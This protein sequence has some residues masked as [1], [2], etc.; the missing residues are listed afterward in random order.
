VV[1]REDQ[2]EASVAVRMAGVIEHRNSHDLGCRGRAIGR[3][4]HAYH[5]Y[6]E[7]ASGPTVSKTSWTYVRTL[8]GPGRPLCRPAQ[9]RTGKAED[10]EACDVRDRGVRWGHSS[11]EGC[12]QGETC[13]VTGAK[14]LT[15]GEAGRFYHTPYTEMDKCAPRNQTATAAMPSCTSVR[16][17]GGAGCVNAHVRICPGGPGK[18]GSLPES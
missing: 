13:G 10:A 16:P 5:R 9:G 8:S 14:A 2:R 11:C 17:K 7:T 4:Q 15:R 6:G 1:I 18:P 3:R 12:E